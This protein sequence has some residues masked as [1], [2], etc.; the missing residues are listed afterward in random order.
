MKKMYIVNNTRGIYISN[1]IYT[2][3]DEPILNNCLLAHYRIFA[4]LTNSDIAVDWILYELL[5]SLLI[6]KNS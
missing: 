1:N 4:Y 2:L 5:F 6:Q 3:N